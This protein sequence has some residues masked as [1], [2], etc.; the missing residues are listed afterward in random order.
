M[1]EYPGGCVSSLAVHM[2]EQP[3]GVGGAAAFKFS[4]LQLEVGAGGGRA[5]MAGSASL[6]GSVCTS[7][8]SASAKWASAGQCHPTWSQTQRVA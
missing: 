6:A 5:Q 2:Q 1:Q 3:E 8:V 7:G 4:D